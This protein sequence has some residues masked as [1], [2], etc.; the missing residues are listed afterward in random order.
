MNN[1][2]EV[3]ETFGSY[4]AYTGSMMQRIIESEDKMEEI[5]Q[6]L[7]DRSGWAGDAHSQCIYGLMLIMKYT[8]AIK[9]LCIELEVSLLHMKTK[10]SEFEA[11]STNVNKWNTW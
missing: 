3:K 2:I 8:T 10:V 9:D 7:A 1:V 11:G 4:K 5:N 6:K